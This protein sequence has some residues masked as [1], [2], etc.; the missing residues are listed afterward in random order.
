VLALVGGIAASD[1]R[2][3]TFSVGVLRRDGMIVPFGAF[4]GKRWSNAWP[5]PNVDINVPITVRDV[6]SRWWGPASPSETWQAWTTPDPQTL[7]ITQLDWIDSFCVRQIALRSDFRPPTSAPPQTEQPYPKEALAVSP[8]E[9]IDRIRILPT[10]SE[11]SRALAPALLEAFNTAERAIADD[12]GYPVSRPRREGR[13][14]EIEALY[15]FGDHPRIYYVE[16]SRRYRRLGQ[17]ADECSTVAFSNGWFSRD[18][19]QVRSLGTDVDAFRCDRNF[20]NYMLPLG[21][22]RT[23]SKLFWLAQF[24]GWDHERYVVI[25]VKA[26]TVEAVLSVWGGSCQ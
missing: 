11:E 26:K 4:D 14:P 15:S 2:P 7:R 25:E 13:A 21:V 23:A 9:T 8:P 12:H 1:S 24:S 16:S 10:D 3:G 19:D 5:A 18:G 20:A 17:R 22:I 6:P